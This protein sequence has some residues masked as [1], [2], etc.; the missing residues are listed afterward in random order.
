[1]SKRL[2]ILSITLVLFFCLAGC[3]HKADSGSIESETVQD[4]ETPLQDAKDNYALYENVSEQILAF[5]ENKQGEIHYASYDRYC[6][7][8]LYSMPHG[9]SEFFSDGQSC[10]GIRMALTCEEQFDETQDK[11][12]YEY[13]SE[14][15]EIGDIVYFSFSQTNGEKTDSFQIPNFMC[16][17][18][19][20]IVEVSGLG[21]TYWTTYTLNG[22]G[23]PDT[24]EEIIISDSVNSPQWEFL[25]LN[26]GT[27]YKIDHDAKALFQLPQEISLT[28]NMSTGLSSEASSVQIYASWLKNQCILCEDALIDSLVSVEDVSALIPDGYKMLSEND[29]TVAD[30]NADGIYDILFTIYPELDIYEDLSAY[31]DGSAYNKIN[32]YYYLELWMLWGQSDGTYREE[33]IMDSVVWEDTYSQE[34]IFGFTSGFIMEYFVGRAPFETVLHRFTYNMFTGQFELEKVYQNDGY[35]QGFAIYT[36]INFGTV[37]NLDYWN[38]SGNNHYDVTVEA[39]VNQNYGNVLNDS[40]YDEYGGL[41]ELQDESLTQSINDSLEIEMIIFFMQLWNWMNATMFCFRNMERC[42]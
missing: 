21:E 42:L 39:Y 14:Y 17:K 6:Y 41:F 7:Y 32:E 23:I 11:K 1:M 13:Y 30:M 36:P 24:I 37:S 33:C 22:S 38:Y 12:E 26:D 20:E 8:D 10:F 35:H 4:F 25:K 19:M 2:L 15:Y 31:E 5:R 34:R 18:D 16:M 29:Y 28:E 27:I 9:Y 3:G 40:A